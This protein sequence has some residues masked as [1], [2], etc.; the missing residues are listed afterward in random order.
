M[1]FYL[2]C[3]L[4]SQ[5]PITSVKFKFVERQVEASVVIPAAKLTFVAES[6]TQVYFAQQVASTCNI[7]FCFETS[8]SQNTRKVFQLAMQQCCEIS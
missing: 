8:W 4:A 7:V 5:K 6:R 3:C 2:P 1:L